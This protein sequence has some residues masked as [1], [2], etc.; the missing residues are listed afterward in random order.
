LVFSTSTSKNFS[1][2][3]TDQQCETDQR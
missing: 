3:L 2:P 1:N